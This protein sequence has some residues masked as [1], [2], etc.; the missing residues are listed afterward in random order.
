MTALTTA[1]DSFR[2]SLRQVRRLR[3][4][5]RS[6]VLHPG[7]EPLPNETA[8]DQ[9]IVPYCNICGGLTFG[10]GPGGR[11]SLYGH[12]PRCKSCQSLER[13]RIIRR[14]WSALPASLKR[15]ASVLQFSPDK[16]VRQS[17]F[18]QYE[19]STFEGENHLDMQNI[20]RPDSTYDI[21]ICN[22]V[23]EH[24]PLDDHAFLELLRILK[25]DGILQI[26]IPDPA[27]RR[28]TTDWGAPR[29]DLHGHFRQYGMDFLDRLLPP[30]GECREQIVSARDDATGTTDLVFFFTKTPSAYETLRA[31]LRRASRRPRIRPTIDFG[32]RLAGCTAISR[33]TQTR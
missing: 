7:R 15:R 31:Q 18:K 8:Q 13:H 9:L 24:V 33:V 25:S 32:A 26:T 30:T 16:S 3:R 21:V 19:V 6:F 5:S 17:W 12:P 29:A 1:S 11:Q 4:F 22:H 10:P 27:R 2:W 23:L 20:D 14:V 28:Q